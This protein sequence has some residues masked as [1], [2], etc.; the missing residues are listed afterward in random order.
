MG[1]RLLV[2]GL[3]EVELAQVH[4]HSLKTATI[5]TIAKTQARSS[6]RVSGTGR[7]SQT[8]AAGLCAAA[9]PGS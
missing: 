2:A 5:R 3:P 8:Q 9:V 7:G 6:L 4:F 1:E